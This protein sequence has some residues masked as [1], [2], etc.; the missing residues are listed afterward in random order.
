MADSKY[1]FENI[2]D[3]SDLRDMLR[4]V[5]LF[6]FKSSLAL[7]FHNRAYHILLERLP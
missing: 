6:A 4:L 3:M 1:S 2:F 7:S 5:S